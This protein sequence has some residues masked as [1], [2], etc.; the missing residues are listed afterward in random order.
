MKLQKAISSCHIRSA[1]YR[2]SNP[3][4]KYF[5]NHP[6][7]LIDRIPEEDKNEEDWQEWDPRNYYDISLPFD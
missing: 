3:K 1:I 5:K 6:V 2:E 4:K 7:N